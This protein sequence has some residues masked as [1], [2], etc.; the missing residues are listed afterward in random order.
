MKITIIDILFVAIIY[1]PRFHDIEYNHNHNI[2]FIFVIKKSDKVLHSKQMM[3]STENRRMK[4][5][6]RHNLKAIQVKANLSDNL[7]D[8]MSWW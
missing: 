2:Y 6:Q 8:E 3:E 5:M 4:T 7:S 1:P